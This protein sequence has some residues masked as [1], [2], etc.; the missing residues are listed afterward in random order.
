MAEAKKVSWAQL[1]IGIMAAVAMAILGVLIFLLTGSGDIFTSYATLYTYMDDSA[2][3]ATSTPVRLNGILVG[4]ISKIEFTG[5]KEKGKIVRI[6][7]SVKKDM[8]GQIPQDSLAV[9]EPAHRL[10]GKF[11]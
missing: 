9:V 7:L 6:T 5:S 11:I 8:L 4:K 10:G 3:M 1:R 2:A